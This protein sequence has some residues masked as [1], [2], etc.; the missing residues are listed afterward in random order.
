MIPKRF[1]IHREGILFKYED[2]NVKKDTQHNIDDFNWE[3]HVYS[4]LLKY[5]PQFA[6]CLNNESVYALQMTKR[7]FGS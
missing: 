1:K 7:S 6:E 3:E 4:I 5:V 2:F